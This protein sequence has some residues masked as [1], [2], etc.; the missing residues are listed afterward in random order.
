MNEWIHYLALGWGVVIA[1]IFLIVSIFY[2]SKHT[3]VLMEWK[4]TEMVFITIVAFILSLIFFIAC[5]F[6]T[7]CFMGKVE[8]IKILS[9][10]SPDTLRLLALDS[11]TCLAGV[12]FAFLGLQHYFVQY[13]TKEGIVIGNIRPGR[14]KPIV[15]KW[16]NIRDYYTRTEYPITNYNFIIQKGELSF[17]RLPISVPFYIRSQFENVIELNLEQAKSKKEGFQTKIQ[18]LSEK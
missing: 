5:C 4:R 14:S 16:E 13:I 11:L 7:A 6:F 18:P 9:E 12:I 17:M 8:G 10:L 15:V 2:K 1:P 3:Q